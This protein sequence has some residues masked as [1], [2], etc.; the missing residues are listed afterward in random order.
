M[1]ADS[2]LLA[3]PPGCLWVA[4]VEDKTPVDFTGGGG[5]GGGAADNSHVRCCSKDVGRASGAEDELFRP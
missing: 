2:E 5:G 1:F 4:S 3:S